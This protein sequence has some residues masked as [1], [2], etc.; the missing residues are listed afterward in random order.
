MKSGIFLAANPAYSAPVMRPVF[1]K[2]D[3]VQEEGS[4]LLIDGGRPPTEGRDGNR[5][6]RAFKAHHRIRM[7]AQ[8]AQDQG[9][10]I[11]LRFGLAVNV[12][13]V[14]NGRRPGARSAGGANIVNHTIR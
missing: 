6:G 5:T 7:P 8:H 1:R 10:D 12:L 13:D 14:D 9:G 2:K 4:D 3:P 11:L